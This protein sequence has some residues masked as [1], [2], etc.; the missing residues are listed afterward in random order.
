M[1]WNEI[2]TQ[3]DADALME[4][5]GSFHDGCVREAH[6]WTGHYVAPDLSMACPCN[7]DNSIRFH[8]QRQFRNPSAIELLFEQVTRF[9]LVP[10]PDNYDTIIFEAAFLVRDGTIFWCTDSRWTPDCRER[11]ECTWIS[12][13]QLRWREVDWLGEELYY[14][15]KE[16]DSEMNDC[17]RNG[18]T[19]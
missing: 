9:N 7:L 14:G 19:S 16:E 4:L 17:G 13:K 11:D 15:P 2:K 8:V 3:A 12:A 18:V 1:N 5:F 10:T 6:L